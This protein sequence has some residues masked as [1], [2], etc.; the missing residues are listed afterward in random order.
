MIHVRQRRDYSDEPIRKGTL[1]QNPFEQFQIWYQQALDDEVLEPNAM[2]LATATKEGRP[3]CRTVLFKEIDKRGWIFYTNTKSRKAREIAENPHGM[4]TILWLEYPRQILL[5]GKI[6]PVSRER[7]EAYFATR[8]RKSQI[9]SAASRQ[10]DILESRDALE[11]QF[12]EIEN[13]YPGQEIPAPEEFGGY[14]IVPKSIEFWHGRRDRRH[15]R[16]LYLF[17]EGRWILDRLSP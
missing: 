4:A 14:R 1:K 2:V 6:E 16:F 10:G 3:S 17:K 7:A 11:K 15:D 5:E 9:N 12:E 8:P 13:R